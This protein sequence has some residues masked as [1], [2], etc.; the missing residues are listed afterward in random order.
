MTAEASYAVAQVCHEANRA[1]CLTLGDASQPAWVD[2]PDWQKASA[3][4]GVE[5]IQAG[6]VT[7]PEQS[8]ES[9]SAQKVADG[10]VFGPTK[11]PVAKTHPC[12]VPFTEL[13]AEQQLKDV[14]FLSVASALLFGRYPITPAPES[15]ATAEAAAPAIPTN[16]GDSPI[17]EL[18]AAGSSPAV[19]TGEPVVVI[20]A[21]NIARIH[22]ILDGIS[23]PEAARA[24]QVRSL[25]T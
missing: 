20:P 21:A 18:A 3:I 4:T 11:D 24:A 15:T 14:L 22:E 13:P 16:P 17:T 10:W 9:W 5:K 12:L 2:A 19:T 6:E 1:F 25:L 8:H 7:R 23:A